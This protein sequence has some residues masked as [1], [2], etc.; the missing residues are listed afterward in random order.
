MRDY[1][2]N[3]IADADIELLFKPHLDTCTGLK[4]RMQLLYIIYL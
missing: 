1:V 3:K 4:S 2:D